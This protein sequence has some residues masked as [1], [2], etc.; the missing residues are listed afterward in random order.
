MKV[1]LEAV[2]VLFGAVRVLFGAVRVCR[3][4]DFYLNCRALDID[5]C[6]PFFDAITVSKVVCILT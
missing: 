2:R 4:S 1:L 6:S 5:L 3:G